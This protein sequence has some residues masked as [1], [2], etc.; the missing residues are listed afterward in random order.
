MRKLFLLI[1]LTACAVVNLAVFALP[2]EPEPE[3]S[4]ADV[5]DGRA[6]H[7]VRHGAG[8]RNMVVFMHGLPGTWAD[9]KPV[10]ARLGHQN[11]VA[12]DRPGF[13]DSTG[14]TQPLFD[15]AASIRKALAGI[16]VNDGNPAT[17]V[18]HSYG[19]SLALAIAQRYP[20]MVKNMLLLA[21]GAG[22][23]RA[24]TM[25]K[26]NARLIQITQLPVV[27]QVSD[28][29]FSNMLLRGATE[30][31]ESTAFSPGDVDPA[32]KRR[33]LTYTLKDSDLIALKDNLLSSE[34][35][36]DRMDA[37]IGKIRLPVTVVSGRS[38]ALVDFAHARRLAADL[39]NGKLVAL[40]GGHMLTYTHAP[41]VAA[42]IREAVR[43]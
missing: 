38:D 26:A 23:V 24:D 31:Q 30:L 17:F 20:R 9:F 6:V 5:G 36:F 39:P 2:D 13:G 14:G 7:F 15:Q 34:P 42:R 21:P 43:R 18:G 12:L 25:D 28:L 16:G 3:G 19:G 33:T 35:D 11:W 4:F 41:E 10:A 29:L 22:G 1:S 8:T 37:G 27:E 40:E 32:H